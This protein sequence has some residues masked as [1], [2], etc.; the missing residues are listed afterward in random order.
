MVIMDRFK[1]IFNNNDTQQQRSLF[2]LLHDQRNSSDQS[3]VFSKFTEQQ[4]I[5]NRNDKMKLHL[6]VNSD[7]TPQHDIA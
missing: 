3:K 5:R 1:R 6:S 7:G 2:I 4:S